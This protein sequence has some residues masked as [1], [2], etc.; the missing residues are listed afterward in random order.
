ME[1]LNGFV[2]FGNEKKICKQINSLYSLI[3]ASKQWHGEFV[4]VCVLI[5]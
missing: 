5:G 4:I 1:Q 3:Q 2:L